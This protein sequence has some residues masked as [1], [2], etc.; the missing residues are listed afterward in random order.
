MNDRDGKICY[1]CDHCHGWSPSKKVEYCLKMATEVLNY[2]DSE[3]LLNLEAGKMYLDDPEH[4]L[5]KLKQSIEN[6][7]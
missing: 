4:Y 5:E 3:H 7:E 1:I 2:P 6:S